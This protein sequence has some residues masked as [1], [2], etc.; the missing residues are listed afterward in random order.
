MPRILRWL[1]IVI[2]VGVT[3]VAAP[4]A[5]AKDVLHPTTYRSASG[6]FELAV[7]PTDRRGVGPA[8]CTMTRAGQE[9]WKRDMD[10]SLWDAVVTTDGRT[11][12]YAY[13]RGYHGW[14]PTDAAE[15]NVIW[16]IILD[17]GGRLV[18]KAPYLRNDQRFMMDPPPSQH[19]IVL[20]ITALEDQDLAIVRAKQ[21][22]NGDVVLWWKYRISTGEHVG[23]V[24]PA[25]PLFNGMGFVKE[26]AVLAV[27]DSPLLAVHW[28]LWRGGNASATV[29]LMNVAGEIVWSRGFPGAYDGFEG[30]ASWW[31]IQESSFSQ[32]TV[33]PRTVSFTMYESGETT[34]MMWP[35][36][37]PSAVTVE[38]AAGPDL[39]TRKAIRD[40][41]PSPR[42]VELEELGRIDLG[43]GA[44]AGSPFGAIYDYA[45]DDRGR[46]GW[47]RWVDGTLRLMLITTDGELVTE[48][49]IGIE[50]QTRV[51][52][53]VW[54]EGSRWLI[55]RNPYEGNPAEAWWVD[56]DSGDV[57]AL[58]DLKAG[59]IE[60]VAPAPE[61]GFIAL[62]TPPGQHLYDKSLSSFDAEGNLRWCTRLES[63]QAVT[64]T[65]DGQIVVIDGIHGDVRWFDAEGQ[66]TKNRPLEDMLGRRPKYVSR[67]APDQDGGIIV[68]DFAGDPTT[69]RFSADGTLTSGVTPR[70]ADGQPFRARKGVRV[71]PEG[72]MW[73]SDEHSFLRLD[74]NGV[75]DRVLGDAPADRPLRRIAGMTIAPD[76]RIYAVNRDNAAIHVFDAAGTPTHIVR[77]D[78]GD[79]ESEGSIAE[80]MV[81]ADGSMFYTPGLQMR[82]KGKPQFLRFAP[83]GTRMGFV[84]TNTGDCW[85]ADWYFHP[86]STRRWQTACR[87]IELVEEDGAVLRTIDRRPDGNWVEVVSAIGVARDGSFAAAMSSMDRTRHDLVSICTYTSE[88]DPVGVMPMVSGG[89]GRGM[90]YAP[91]LV[92]IMEREGLWVYDTRVGGSAKRVRLPE[93]QTQHEPYWYLYASH[94]P[95]EIVVREA[96]SFELIRYRMPDP[97]PIPPSP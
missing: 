22:V 69:N 56:V 59:V 31:D 49:A 63:P 45:L 79:F 53:I 87:G 89:G 66:Q 30:R 91:P 60:S 48:L 43:A 40:Q 10:V 3:A 76:G 12:G 2:G 52:S 86:E 93:V 73:T 26:L 36:D 81:S 84:P 9:L 54:C 61:G 51:P 11:I 77:P 55:Y 71:D 14:T 32:F 39:A 44:P 16:V 80:I 29:A 58:P 83:D 62:A 24:E 13:E 35:P 67:V 42:V 34:R 41:L 72:R 18:T 6:D 88:G 23:D 65:T 78:P 92:A 38:V 5:M 82:T 27:P 94:T 50:G 47:M 97:Q 7:D 96:N 46:I 68:F 90:A 8:T 64:V 37:D 33:G 15:G 75:V 20:G 57:S 28:Y 1:V 17:A 70:H 74:D 85:S 21:A 4:R 19:P 25:M 95:G